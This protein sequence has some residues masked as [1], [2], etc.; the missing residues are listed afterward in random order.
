[1]RIIRGS[2]SW[3]SDSRRAN[4]K[5]PLVAV[6]GRPNVGKS[7]IFNRITRTRKAI[8]SPVSGVTRDRHVAAA[9]WRER[10]FLVMDTGGWV[11]HSGELFESAIREQV[12]FALDEC[13][14]VLCVVDAHTGPT[15]VD[16]DIA[17]MLQRASLPVML[18]V[19]KVDGP[20]QEPE[21]ASFYNLGLGDPIS[22][23][24]AGGGGFAEMLDDLI[25]RLR[26]KGGGDEL[27]RPRPLV[28]IVGRPNV[29]KS[30]L[31]NAIVGKP[32]R[33]VTEVAGTTRDAADTVVAYYQQ[34]LTLIDTAGLR[35]RAKVKEALEF[36]T[37]V[38]TSRAI[39]ECDVAVVMVDA[40]EGVATQDV[41]ILQEADEAGKGMVLCINKWDLVEKDAKTAD[42]FRRVLDERFA[43]LS[44]V[45]K[46]FASCA[47]KQRVFKVLELVIR[48]HEERQKRIAT[49]ELNRWLETI[50]ASSPPPATKGRDMRLIYVT[51]AQAEPP[52][53]VFFTRDPELVGESYRRFLERRLREQYGFEGVP[54]RLTF[55]KRT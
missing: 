12:Q 47:D 37:T 42:Q 45:P 51:Q 2:N 33:V 23:S 20:A 8:T 19:N 18:A 43:N 11:P 39:E 7:T 32:V 10:K 27:E 17:R 36:Y 13:D 29:G 48:V 3:K 22:I 35:R 40:V 38:R 49:P 5:L 25:E 31:V 52:L 26:E 28:A 55:R 1:M 9:E 44:H 30:S 21:A 14:L 15:D 46:V 34:R 53:F 41:R 24:A 6:V 16:L 54:I 50:M 4:M